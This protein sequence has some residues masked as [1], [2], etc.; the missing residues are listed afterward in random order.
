MNR[1]A[2]RRM[3]VARHPS[4]AASKPPGLWARLLGCR[5][6]LRECEVGLGWPFS[7]ASTVIE[8][9]RRVCCGYEEIYP[10]R[11]G[12]VA[13]EIGTNSRATGDDARPWRSRFLSASL[14]VLFFFFSSDID[15]S[16]I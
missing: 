8:T 3:Q 16:P 7:G 12:L 6:P 11:G 4:C 10:P 14:G 5:D 13:P 2:G 1:V 9:C 15:W